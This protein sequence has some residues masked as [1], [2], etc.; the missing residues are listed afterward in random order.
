MQ[1]MH[2]LLTSKA[3]RNGLALLL[4]LCFV[5]TTEVNA[6]YLTPAEATSV[7]VPTTDAVKVLGH[8]V[9]T[10]ETTVKVVTMADKMQRKFYYYVQANIQN[11]MNVE[12]ALED[13][14]TKMVQIALEQGIFTVQDVDSAYNTIDELLRI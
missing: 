3:W 12:D 13:T 4:L 6:Q 5:G 8:E 9:A 2:S 10:L 1:K 7:Y 11:G 14:R